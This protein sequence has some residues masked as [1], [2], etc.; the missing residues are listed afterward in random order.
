[1]IKKY[2]VSYK[3]VLPDMEL[4]FKRNY[5]EIFYEVVLF[6]VRRFSNLFDNIINARRKAGLPWWKCLE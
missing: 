5:F 2:L 1:M 4:K 6:I 3:T